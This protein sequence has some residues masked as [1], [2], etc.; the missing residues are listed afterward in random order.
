MRC[1]TLRT[2]VIGAV[3]LASCLPLNAVPRVAGPT[4]TIRRIAISNGGHDL[5]VEITASTPITPRTQTA[6]GPDRLI[7]DF[8]E[9]LPNPELHKV[10]VN[11]GNLRDVRVGLFSLNPRVTRV[12]L[13]LN[14]PSQYHVLSSGNTTTV[15]LVPAVLGPSPAAEITTRPAEAPPEKTLPTTASRLHDRSPD[16]TRQK[17]SGSTAMLRRIRVLPETENFA[18]EITAD[19]PIAP[20]T[21][22]VADPY[23]LI[24]DFPGIVPSPDLRD[25]SFKRADA[26]GVRVALFRA[27]PPLT[28]VV[29]DLNT[30]PQF[31]LIPAGKSVVVKLAEEARSLTGVAAGPRENVQPGTVPALASASSA[32]RPGSRLRVSVQAGQLSIWA[33]GASLSEVLD[34]IHRQTGAAISSPLGAGSERV[35]VSLG[36]GS[37][38]EVLERLLSGLP[39]NFVIVGVTG[40]P[41][42]VS[43]VQLTPKTNDEEPQPLARPASPPPDNATAEPPPQ[44]EPLPPPEPPAETPPVSPPSTPDN[45]P[46]PLPPTPDLPPQVPQ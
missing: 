30:Q 33:D 9:A 46:E 25:M 41:T 6:T 27:N 35:A 8:P 23:R 19:Q 32:V 26:R 1:S 24:I 15:K 5:T 38:P 18:V 45:P 40:D 17:Q 39:F 12:V 3:L 28:R 29:L 14:A 31:Q 11:R 34:E 7:V 43:S 10:L 22:V 37:T 4:A 2:I 42:R 36:P 20:L 16:E 21:R 13:D 44:T